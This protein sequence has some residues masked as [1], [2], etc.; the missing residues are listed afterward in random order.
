MSWFTYTA[1]PHAI[2]SL[3]QP[4]QCFIAFI[5]S[6]CFSCSGTNSSVIDYLLWFIGAMICWLCGIGFSLPVKWVL[7]KYDTNVVCPSLF[8]TEELILCFWHLSWIVSTCSFAKRQQLQQ[9]QRGCFC[10]LGV[11]VTRC[12]LR[13][14][15]IN[16]ASCDSAPYWGP[17]KLSL[18]VSK[19][20]KK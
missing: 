19:E 10:P 13:F 20:S 14:K 3:V 1:H 4:H 15:I 2:Y 7:Q 9:L 11:P 18:P 8:L 12:Q 16:T 6:S 5:Q 17:W